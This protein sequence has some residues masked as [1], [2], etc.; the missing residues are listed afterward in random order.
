MGQEKRS[1]VVSGSKVSFIRGFNDIYV[2][3]P[4]ISIYIVNVTAMLLD[5]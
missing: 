4:L 3:E 2:A 5:Y 1:L